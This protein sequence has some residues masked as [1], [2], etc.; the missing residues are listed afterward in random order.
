[1]TQ[2]YYKEHKE[3]LKVSRKKWEEKNQDYYKEYYEKNKERIKKNK[4]KTTSK[5][6]KTH[7]DRQYKSEEER[8]AYQR[9]DHLCRNYKRMDSKKGF[10]I[11]DN[12]T[13]DWIY[14]NILYKKCIYCNCEGWDVLGVDRINN[15]KP[16]TPNNCVPSCKNC[17]DKRNKKDFY[18][19]FLASFIENDVLE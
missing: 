5:H 9:A 16:H 18:D 8:N 1:M 12:I 13:G 7:S 10:D 19:F 17:N 2:K 6:P 15:T 3:Q 4:K 11:S 14:K